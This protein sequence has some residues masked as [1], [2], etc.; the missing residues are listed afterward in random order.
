MITNQVSLWYPGSCADLSCEGQID[1]FS[2]SCALLCPGS[3]PFLIIRLLPLSLLP[4]LLEPRVLPI[5]VPVVPTQ[6][7]IHVPQ[8]VFWHILA[9]AFRFLPA[10]TVL[11]ARS[12]LSPGHD[13]LTQS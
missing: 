2:S 9:G 13:S 7:A 10:E 8:L 3:V 12:F 4:C 1:L 11:I 5:A 6:A